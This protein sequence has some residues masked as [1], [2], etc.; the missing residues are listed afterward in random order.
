MVVG[1]FMR[2]NQRPSEI[3][4]PLSARGALTNHPLKYGLF[5][6]CRKAG[7]PSEIE[8]FDYLLSCR[9]TLEQLVHPPAIGRDF[10]GI[11]RADQHMQSLGKIGLH[12]SLYYC[13]SS[14]RSSVETQKVRWE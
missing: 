4:D 11:C 3:L 5:V 6:P 2:T 8:F 7:E 14:D 12:L 1:K 9:V 10:A 13:V